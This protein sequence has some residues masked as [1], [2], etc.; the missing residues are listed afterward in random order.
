MATYTITIKEKT[1]AGK[2]LLS[3]LRSLKDIVIIQPSGI[4]ESLT[5]IIEGRV[6]FAEN[7]K[8]LINQ[9]SK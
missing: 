5:D 3:L 6:Y 1:K 4:D 8:D 2:A 7:A 9:C